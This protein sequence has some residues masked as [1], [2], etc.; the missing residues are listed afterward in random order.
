[1]ETNMPLPL[2]WLGAGVA[3][4]FAGSKMARENQKANGHIKHFPGECHQAVRPVNGSVV[5]CGIYELFQHTGIW[6]DGEII[7]LKGNGL[8]RAVSPSRFISERSGNRIY[9]ACDEFLNPLTTANAARI[10]SNH[11]FDY[12]EYDLISNNCHRFTAQCLLGHEVDVTLFA[13]LNE[14]ISSKFDTKIHWQPIDLD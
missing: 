14:I 6:V 11:V 8:V 7:E 13:D 9:V 1:M 5:C 2:V 10:A 4:V 3:A 12:Q